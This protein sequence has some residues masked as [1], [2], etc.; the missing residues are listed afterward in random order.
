MITFCYKN[1]LLK[2]LMTGIYGFLFLFMSGMSV[3]AQDFTVTG[4]VISTQDQSTIPGVTVVEV[5]TQRGTLTDEEGR[6]SLNISGPNAALRFSFVGFQSLTI[7]VDGRSEIDVRM[8]VE[9]LELSDVVVTA[10]GLERDR[11]TIGYSITQV[12]SE[13]LVQGTEANVVNLLQGQV[14]GVTVAPVGGGP[15]ASSRVTIRGTSSLTDDNQPLYVVD[16]IPIDNTNIGSAGM[17][18]GFDG[19]DGIQSLNPQDIESITVLKG[20][21]AAALYGERARDGV[22]LVTTKQGQAGQIS[23]NFSSSTTIERARVDQFDFQTVYGQGGTG[24]PRRRG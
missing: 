6:F 2:P 15:G 13:N 10:I 12:R 3:Q 19:G 4:T 1:Y 5:G 23:V 17:W 20:A 8:T 14:S 16:G 22:I 9:V 7:N 18:G 21:S 11:K 24:R